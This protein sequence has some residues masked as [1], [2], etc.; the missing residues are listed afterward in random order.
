MQ[1]VLGTLFGGISKPSLLSN[2]HKQKK[3]KKTN[4]QN[5]QS[6]QTN[7]QTYTN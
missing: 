7:Q 4:K 1:K 5:K 3:N 2:L 6:K